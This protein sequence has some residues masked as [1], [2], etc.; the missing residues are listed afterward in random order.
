MGALV[1]AGDLPSIVQKGLSI[2]FVD[3]YRNFKSMLPYV[4]RFKKAEQAT[5]FDLTISD[6][7]PVSPFN[8]DIAYS[9][10]IE[11]YKKPVSETEYAQGIKVTR[12]LLRNDLYGVIQDRVRLMATNMRQLRESLGAFPFNNAFNSSFTV[13]DG[14]SLC[15]SAHTSTVPG[16]ATQSNSTSLAFSAAN[17]SVVRVAFKKLQTDAGNIMVAGPDTIILPLDLEEKGVQILRSMGQVDTSTNNVNFYNNGRWKMIVWDNFLSSPTTWFLANGER[18]RKQLVFREWEGVQFFRSGESDTLV[19][20]HASYTS[21]GIS[22]A[23]YRYIY[24]GNS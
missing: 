4:Y 18:M 11:G 24:G 9:D 7:A 6:L 23:E 16:V 19:S 13:G 22:S 10:I 1:T 20:K 15:N 14:L 2:V 5:E 17:L 12:K 21:L 3:E 8:G